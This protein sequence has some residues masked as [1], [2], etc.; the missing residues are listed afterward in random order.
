MIKRI[1][2]YIIS[3]FAGH[4][5]REKIVLLE[6]QIALL[7]LKVMNLEKQQTEHFQ[8][9]NELTKFQNDLIKIVD[10]ASEFSSGYESPIDVGMYSFGITD[11][12]DEFMN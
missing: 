1:I 11:D 4:T 12:D 9:I 8:T 6:G 10:F 2:N 5:Q 3:F 7:S